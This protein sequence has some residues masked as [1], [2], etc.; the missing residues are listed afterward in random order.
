[1]TQST[2][3]THLCSADACNSVADNEI[4]GKRVCDY[5]SALSDDLRA[6]ID[7]DAQRARDKLAKDAPAPDAPILVY[8]NARDCEHGSQRG[9][10]DLC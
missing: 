10:C 2:M 9:E 8:P 5:H 3:T 6:R 7:A 4:N 1:M